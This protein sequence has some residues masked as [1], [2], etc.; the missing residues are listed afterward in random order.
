MKTKEN[1]ERRNM[2]N[3]IQQAKAHLPL[4]KIM[5]DITG[6]T[7][8]RQ[9]NTAKAEP[10]KPVVTSRPLGELLD[11]ICG[12]LRRYVVFPLQEQVAVISA[13]ILHTWVFNAFD[14]TPY[15]FVFSA[16]KRSGKSR[17][18]EVIEQL[19]RNPRLTEGA[20]VAALMRSVDEGNPPTMLLDEV[21][22]IYSKKS[23][24]E[25]ENTRRFLNAGYRRGANFLR[26]V[27]QGAD[28]Q[29]RDFPAF[30][31]KA[32]AG[33]DRC[34][35]HTVLD[36]SLPI[37]LVRQSRE[38]KAERFRRREVE[39]VVAPIRAELEALAQLPDLI[40]ALRA[41]RP[42]LPGELND[43][44]QDIC[45]PLIAIADF[46]GGEWPERLRKALV[47]LCAQE[48]DAD[49][50]V[51][52]LGA[53]KAVFDTSGADKLFTAT[54]LKDVVA[55]ADDAPWPSW[56]E[57]SLNHNR[58]DSAASKLARK[59]KPYGIKPIK[60]RIGDE[61]GKG[62][63]RAHFEKAWE[64]YLPA[65]SPSFQQRFT[66]GTR[67][68][69][70]Q[71][72][73]EDSC[74]SFA[75]TS[76]NVPLSGEKGGT[77][78]HE[79]KTVNVPLV[80]AVP[81]NPDEGATEIQPEP[82]A[83][84]KSPFDHMSDEEW[85]EYEAQF[86]A[87]KTVY[88]GDWLWFRDA[89]DFMAFCGR[90]HPSPETC[91]GLHDSPQRDDLDACLNTLS[92]GRELADEA[93]GFYYHRTRHVGRCADCQ[94]AEWIWQGFEVRNGFPWGDWQATSEERL[95]EQERIAREQ[96]EH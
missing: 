35:P 1:D 71:F 65:S 33:I 2:H 23:D 87:S 31:P 22:T 81:L 75:N 40:D 5:A 4:P 67:G 78:N 73:R 34:L 88:P 26:C 49:I 43:R 64:R 76:V 38:E 37:E 83:L 54:I 30:C 80:N 89:A 25:A 28:I 42:S 82:A 74:S 58:L 20:S 8:S 41:A 13:W 79:G 93:D 50:G 27:G 66:R 90:E 12:I 62:Y 51:K 10:P 11:A 94:E 14:Y 96:L 32:L 55:N 19:A 3:E 9:T 85:A 44:A 70:P 21:D 69:N 36:R 95:A 29:V 16:A 61:T 45:E 56:F 18:L 72:T 86:N 91:I 48:E 47:R 39:A 6:E 52:L 68:T 53:I 92:C 84:P 17:V 63:H 60:I 77:E 46:A 7:K 59:L 24:A 57:D 15:L